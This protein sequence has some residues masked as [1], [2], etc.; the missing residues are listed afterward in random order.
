MKKKH[1]FLG[2]L[3]TSTIIALAG[4][5][6]KKVKTDGLTYK[7]SDYV[8]LGEYKALTVTYPE[9]MEITQEDVDMTVQERLDEDAEYIEITD[10]PIQNGDYISIDFTGTID[11][12]EFE[13]G[14]EEEYEFTI[15]EGEFL[16]EFENNL[17][18]KKKEETTKFSITFPE[19]YDE[20]LGGKEAEFTVTINEIFEVKVPEYN[21]AYVQNM[22]DYNTKEEYEASI[23]EELTTSAQE[24]TIMMA[25]E[26][27]LYM[28]V[29]NAKVEGYPQ[30]LYDICY[31]D[32]E[33]SYQ[34]YA[35]MFGM[36]YEE[37]I[38]DFVGE[39]GIEE[40][41]IEQVNDIL[42]SQAIAEKEGIALSEEEYDEQVAVMAVEN[43]YESVDA[44]LEDYGKDYIVMMLTRQKVIE[45][46][47]ESANLKEVSQE[48][49]YGEEALEEEEEATEESVEEVTD[50]T[51]EEEEAT[52][53]TVE[54]EEVT[55]ETEQ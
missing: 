29:E 40:L 10:R 7:A 13:G 2:M 31:A 44:L 22:T 4:C 6:E 16:E 23:K 47:Y 19:D 34:S 36:E 8:T 54:Q 33:A 46:L 52:D 41:V 37:F 51:E 38:T 3:L 32:T 15:G 49:Y 14:S 50:E 11:G 53:E 17:I 25:G 5:G 55:D 42:V 18:G 12:E 45:F 43:E 1:I 9:V 20:T 30:E 27:A 24:E 21:D 26:D 28:A 35:A 48:E 39:G